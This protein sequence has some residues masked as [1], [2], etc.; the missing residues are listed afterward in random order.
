MGFEL[1]P[2]GD[3]EGEGSLF[4]AE[5]STLLASNNKDME[6]NF[7][8]P[9]CCSVDSSALRVC[10]SVEPHTCSDP[11]MAPDPVTCGEDAFSNQYGDFQIENGRLDTEVKICNFARSTVFVL[12]CLIYF[13]LL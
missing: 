4:H 13:L 7:G 11:H 1:E 10:D 6:E 2:F 3:N 12:F 8:I 5:T 9:A